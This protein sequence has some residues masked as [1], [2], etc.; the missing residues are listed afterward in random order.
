MR[1]YELVKFPR[2][3]YKEHEQYSEREIILSSKVTK[4]V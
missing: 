1:I 2:L 3:K 4:Q